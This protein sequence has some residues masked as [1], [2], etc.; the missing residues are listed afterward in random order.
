MVEVTP[1]PEASE[2]PS[3]EPSGTPSPVTSATPEPTPTPEATASPSPSST[4]TEA[5]PAES[6]DFTPVLEKLDQLGLV[7]ELAFIALCLVVLFQAA[8][9]V[10]S[11]R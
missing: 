8:L 7:L 3:P 10:R 6:A 2:S 11:I 9:F 4:P 5:P 1:T